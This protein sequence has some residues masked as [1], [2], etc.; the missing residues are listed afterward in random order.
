MYTYL[1]YLHFVS[2]LAAPIEEKEKGAFVSFLI[3]FPTP[4]E[5]LKVGIEHR[6]I[7]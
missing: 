4:Y 7:D 5:S 2:H 6:G 3:Y 1:R